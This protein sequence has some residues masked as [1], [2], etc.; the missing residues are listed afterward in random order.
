[1]NQITSTRDQEIFSHNDYVRLY[2]NPITMT[3]LKY[4]RDA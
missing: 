2:F 1:M 4:V 3:V